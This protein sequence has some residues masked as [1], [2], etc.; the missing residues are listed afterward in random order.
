MP[1]AM[2]STRGAWLGGRRLMALDGFGMEDSDSEEN[3]AHFGY[4]GK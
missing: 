1:C 3:A 2:R 4:A